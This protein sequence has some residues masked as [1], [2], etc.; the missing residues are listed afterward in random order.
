MEQARTDEHWVEW[1][2]PLSLRRP[3]S[4]WEALV[5]RPNVELEL[6]LARGKPAVKLED[7]DEIA[8]QRLRKLAATRGCAMEAVERDSG[9]TPEARDLDSRAGSRR[10]QVFLS[11]D[12][13]HLPLLVELERRE[14]RG[15]SQRGRA[16]LRSG[17]L[18]GYPACCSHFFAELQRQD[19]RA[20]L[21]A[22]RRVAP[23]HQAS[24]PW[25]NLFPPL[26]SPVI[27]FPCSFSCA[28]SLEAARRA[29]AALP[30]LAGPGG[31]I[32]Q[33]L[34]GVTLVFQRFL[35][36]HLHDARTQG[37][38]VRYDGVSDALSWTTEPLLRKSPVL[39]RF[40]EQ[41]TAP[42]AQADALELDLD[43]RTVTLR[44]EEGQ[45]RGFL[46]HA[47]LQVHF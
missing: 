22:Y 7:R 41:V 24:D 5:R 12:H 13:G 38:V 42:F 21:D 37:P 11:W 31:R 39:R 20:V 47:P 46:L 9:P 29:V 45:R 6:F 33:L 18:L 4:D 43:A 32:H 35:F 30:G 16:I 40:R 10:F 15:G 27:W 23:A 26:A 8:V 28:A 2:T 19:D 25:L 3:V 17:E 14:R 36:V 1:E 44:V 34:A